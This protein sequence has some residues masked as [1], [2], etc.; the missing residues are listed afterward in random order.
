M[1]IA[2]VIGL[3]LSLGAIAGAIIAGGDMPAFIDVPSVIVVVLGCVGVTFTKWPME[4]VKKAI[5]IAMKTIFY[6]PADPKD[7]IDQIG[8]LAETA[9]RESVFA[10]EK[11]PIEDPF[12]KKAMTLAADNRPPEIISAILQLEIDA[13]EE[14]HKAGL[15]FFENLAADGPA[16]GMI[17]TLIGLVIMLGNLSDQAAIGPAMAIALLTTF[18]GAI[19]ATVFANPVKNK[20][21][22][23]SKLES[24]KMNIIVAGT[25]GIV[26]GENPRLIK[27][28]LSAFLAPTERASDEDDKGGE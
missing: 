26:A 10:L 27:E 6:T 15:D 19:I 12:L 21:Q 16:M 2:T 14:R 7:T 18:Y 17:G 8:T 9:R 3:V 1:D 11:V 4:I 23:R 20:L 13:L 5:N 28:K 22:F 25:L 24:V